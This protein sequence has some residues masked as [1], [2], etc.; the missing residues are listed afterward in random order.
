MMPIGLIMLLQNPL[1]GAL[2]VLS[3]S[4][5]FCVGLGLMSFLDERDRFQ[6]A[7]QAP[8]SSNGLF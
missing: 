8:E 3:A 7:K 1:I 4:I 2:L 5:M 6:I